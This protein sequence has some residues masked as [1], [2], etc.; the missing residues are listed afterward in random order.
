MRAGHAL[1]TLYGGVVA[2]RMPRRQAIVTEL[3]G[4]EDLTN[5]IALNATMF[6]AATVVGPAVAGVTYAIFGPAWRRWSTCASPGC[7]RCRR[8]SPAG[9]ILRTGKN[10]HAERS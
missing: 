1:F 8:I 4:R 6:K 9:G 10:P 2:D 3:V 7:A 5:A